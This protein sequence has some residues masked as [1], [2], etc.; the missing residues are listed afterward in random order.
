MATDATHP[1]GDERDTTEPAASG[2]AGDSFARADAEVPR[3]DRGLYVEVLMQIAER[4]E[5]AEQWLDLGAST[6]NVEYAAFHL[7]MVLELIVM[8]S[9]VTN[10][11]RIEEVATAIAKKRAR[12]I[13]K[14]VKAANPDYW[15]L[16]ARISAD[17]RPV[18]VQMS[19]EGALTE[20]A[21]GRE[22][23]KLSALLHAQNPLAS[24][25]DVEKAHVEL[26]RLSTAIRKLLNQHAVA[27]AD[28][29]YMLLGE[30]GEEGCRVLGIR[31]ERWKGN[32][33][34]SQAP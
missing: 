24:P 33:P 20:A 16:P 34:P 12:E 23:G 8:G 19:V 25:V 18:Q 30:I 6:R 14:N 21:W 27:L 1:S 5:A 2:P 10:R 31:I 3:D 4:L 15:P 9:L 7:R 32:W 28:R 22:W 29:N 11:E 26:G 17:E 13:R